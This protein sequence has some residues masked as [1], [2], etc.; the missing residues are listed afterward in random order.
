MGAARRL[1]GSG[2]PVTPPTLLEQLVKERAIL[3]V[4][5][6]VL[7]ELQPAVKGD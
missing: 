2:G 5:A 4:C 3:D 7:D 1:P 6:G